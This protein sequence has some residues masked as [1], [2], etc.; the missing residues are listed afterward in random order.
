MVKLRVL[1]FGVS[2][3]GYGARCLSLQKERVVGYV[4]SQLQ[5][6]GAGGI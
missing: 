1:S 4:L 2:L 3:D 6:G 5:C